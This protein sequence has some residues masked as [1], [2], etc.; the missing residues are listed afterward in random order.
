V[1]AKPRAT[2]PAPASSGPGASEGRIALVLGVAGGFAALLLV[3]YL[4]AA[5]GRPPR[6]LG[7][8]LPLA[9]TLYWAQN[10]IVLFLL[11]WVG[12]RLGSSV[13]LD[14]PLLRAR[15]SRT[16]PKVRGHWLVSA[17]LGV[18]ASLGI[19]LL[20][21]LVFKRAVAAALE[22]AGP[23]MQHVA[24][25]K[26]ALASFYGGIVEEIELRL[27]FMTLVAWCLWKVVR[28]KL[29][30]I[31]VAANVVAALAFGAGHLPFAVQV[32]G[33]TPALVVRTIVLNSMA[34]VIFGALYTRWGLERA[35]FAHFCADI[36]LHA[37]I[38]G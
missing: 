21:V 1:V 27:F 17:A 29:G 20:D 16:V 11:A 30:A 33:A 37:G 15:L 22:Q 13:G 5:S 2:A 9:L 8:P 10:S 32:L 6:T 31:L 12:L 3:P 7:L 18:L 23:S 25:W 14:V 36:V 35:M 4:L 24:R 34:G 28:A 38:G 19:V 26:G